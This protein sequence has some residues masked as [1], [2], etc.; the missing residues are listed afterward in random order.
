MII[1]PDVA[2]AVS[3]LQRRRIEVYPAVKFPVAGS[4]QRTQST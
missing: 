2:R 3:R 4:A 1:L